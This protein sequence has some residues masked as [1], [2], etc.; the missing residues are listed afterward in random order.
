[1]PTKTTKPRPVHAKTLRRSRA[2]RREP[3]AAERAL[4]LR[5]RNRAIL[6]CKFRRQFA[7]GDYIVDFCCVERQLVIE[8]DGEQHAMQAKRYD[9]KRTAD[10]RTFG[11]QVVRFWNE[12]V[13]K[14][15]DGVV[16]EIARRLEERREAKAG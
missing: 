5:L 14:N 12:E 11:F 10:L 13:L 4:W 2:M 1:M 7:V 9:E 15:L 16:E 3:T 6:G 8:L